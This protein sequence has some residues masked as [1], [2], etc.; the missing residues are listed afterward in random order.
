MRNIKSQTIASRGRLAISALI[1]AFLFISCTQNV[2]QPNVIIL[3]TDDQGYGDFSVN[4][5]PYLKTPNMDRLHDMSVRFTDFHAAP[6]CTATRSQMLTG[7]DA[8]HNG[9]CDPTGQT[10]LLDTS[11]TIMSDV[12]LQNGYNT[13]LYGKWHLGG[14]FTHY[15]PHERGFQ[16]AVH[17]LRGGHWSSPNYWNS[18]QMDD[19]YYHNG[20]LEQFKGYATDIWFELGKKFVSRSKEEDKPFFLYL[21]VNAPHVPWLVPPKYREPY[22]DLGLDEGS[23]AFYSMIATVDDNLGSFIDFL[24]QEDQW[25]NTIFIFFTDNGTTLYE[26]EYNAGMRGKKGDIYE[27]GHRVPIYFSWPNGQLGA[28]R[29]IDALS[30]CQDLLPT[31]MDLCGLKAKTALNVEGKSLAPILQGKLQDEL[32]ERV[33]VVQSGGELLKKYESTVMWQKWR[34]VNGTELYDL[35]SD[36]PQSKD[37]SGQHPDIASK[38]K[39]YYDGWWQ[40][41][42]I[43]TKPPLY[44]IG[45]EEV[46]LT[47]YDWIEEGN[48][49]VYNWEH[50]RYGQKKNGKYLVQFESDGRY[51]ISLRRWPK[52]ADVAIRAGVPAFDTFDPYVTLAA[53]VALDIRSARIKVGDQ[54]LTETIQ[55]QD[56]EVVFEA[57][58]M[59]GEHYLQTWFIDQEDQEFGAYYIYINRLGS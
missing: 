56:K 7:I 47:G 11:Y 51:R 19:Y 32:D 14:N 18:D 9:A 5:H 52:E 24:K 31:L 53:G 1:L 3:L 44:Y 49:Q 27:G 45:D 58:I 36:L 42:K 15:R 28:P 23:I 25:D 33:L 22:M 6:L 35:N 34:L 2:K 8:L 46:M 12:F 43:D 17:F 50:L 37:I 10:T 41:A 4:G 59:R 55:E 57:D 40:K 29:D 38:L 30:Q 21:P 13:A 39:T 20:E 16:D 54:I 26:Q 48:G